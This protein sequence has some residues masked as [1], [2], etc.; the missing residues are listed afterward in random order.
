MAL[1]NQSF[2]Q[3]SV[4]H[5]VFYEVEVDID[6]NPMMGADKGQ[7]KRVITPG[8]NRKHYL[9]DG[10]DGLLDKPKPGRPNQLSPHQLEQ[11]KKFIEK[12]CYQAGRWTLNS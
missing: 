6:L 7:Q 5:P 10:L 4:E 8:C 2:K 9:T 3:F 1:I 11:L 12:P